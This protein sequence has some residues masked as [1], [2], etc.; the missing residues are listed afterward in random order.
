ML[1]SPSQLSEDIPKMSE[2]VAP[3]WQYCPWL[4]IT[5]PD[6]ISLIFIQLNKYHYLLYARH[7]SRHL[8]DRWRK[9]RGL[10]SWSCNCDLL[11]PLSFFSTRMWAENGSYLSLGLQP[12]RAQGLAPRSSLN[13]CWIVSVWTPLSVGHPAY[14]YTLVSHTLT[15]WPTP[16]LQPCWMFSCF[17]SLGDLS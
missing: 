11:I 1:V 7:C 16:V 17:L 12:V 6:E 10:P 3:G 4:K 5:D 14:P 2:D 13:V 15:P 8:G 9:Q